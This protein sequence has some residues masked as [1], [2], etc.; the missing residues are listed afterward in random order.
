MQINPQRIVV[1]LALCLM[2]AA[3][4]N[5]SVNAGVAV[6]ACENPDQVV[7]TY[8]G[9]KKITLKDVDAIVGGQ[10]KQMEKDKLRLRKQ[11]ID[12]VAIEALAVA[13][14]AKKGISKDD[15]IKSQIEQYA[16]KPTED[17][18]AAFFGQNQAQMPPGSTLES[19]HG[20]LEQFLTQQKQKDAVGKMVEALRKQVDLQVQLAEPRTAVEALGPSKGPADAKVTIVEFSDFECPFCSRAEA[21]VDQVLAANLG[22]VRI[23]YRHFPLSQHANAQK[24]AE[25]SL[26]A[27]DQG[28]FWEYK[29][30]LFENQTGLQVEKL[31]SYAKDLSLDAAKFDSCLDSGANKAKVDADMKAAMAASIG[32]TPSFFVN[33]VAVEPSFEEFDRVIKQE[34]AAAK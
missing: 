7:A 8:S 29:K 4:K 30:V 32:G 2:L 17:E 15:W 31:K 9:G 23:V 24:A 21:T 25:A 14:S 6:T 19:M 1:A 10:L 33:G 3:C 5:N 26:C 12:Q 18:I 16:T 11:G 13:E 28:K 34:L 27:H 22:K 20:Q